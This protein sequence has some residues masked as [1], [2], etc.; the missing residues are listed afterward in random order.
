M[1]K[2][3][4]CDNSDTYILANEAITITVSRIDAAAIRVNK[5]VIF[6]NYAP[7]TDCIREINNTHADDAKDLEAVMP[8]H[9]LTYYSKISRDL[10]QYFR[11]EPNATITDSESFKFKARIT[12]RFPVAGNTKNVE[13]AVPLK[14]LSN[15]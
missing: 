4:L 10:W 1:L 2:S 13:I 14:Y 11:D 6:K 8:M 15:F 7:F 9:N 12:G 3:S 5:K